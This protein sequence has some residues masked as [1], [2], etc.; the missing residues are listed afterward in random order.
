MIVPC[1]NEIHAHVLLPRPFFYLIPL[2]DIS[3]THWYLLDSKVSKG[4]A[5]DDVAAQ[6]HLPPIPA[7]DPFHFLKESAAYGRAELIS[8]WAKL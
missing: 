1:V 4:L 7:S 2:F 8:H 3:H 5:L 6:V